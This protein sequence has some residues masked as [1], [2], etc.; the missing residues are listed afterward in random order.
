MARQDQ[1]NVLG[2]HPGQ[3]Q[4]EHQALGGFIEV[5]RRPEGNRGLVGLQ[6]GTQTVAHLFFQV[7]EVTNYSDSY[8]SVHRFLKPCFTSKDK[9]SSRKIQGLHGVILG[10]TDKLPGSRRNPQAP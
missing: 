6:Q 7:L 3:F 1:G 10:F 5:G 9:S 2:C 8:E 4:A